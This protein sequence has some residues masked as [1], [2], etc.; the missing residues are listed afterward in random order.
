LI[1]PEV[2]QIQFRYFDGNQTADE[3]DMLQ[4]P[5]LPVAVE[6]SIWLKSARANANARESSSAD[7]LRGTREYK[8]VVF[9]PMAALSAANAASSATGS[10]DS[11]TD[12]SSSSS[13]EPG[14]SPSTG[15][16]FDN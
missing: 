1:A 7:T 2:A 5:Q 3:W 6:V 15:S 13:T 9:L 11:S 14:S 16:A 8:Q 10:T 4:T 12:S